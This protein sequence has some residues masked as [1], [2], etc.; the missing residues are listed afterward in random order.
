MWAASWAGGLPTPKF[1]QCVL[2]GF[3]IDCHAIACYAACVAPCMALALALALA[4]FCLGPFV[5]GAS[6]ASENIRELLRYKQMCGLLDDYICDAPGKG[7]P[8]FSMTTSHGDEWIPWQE[9]WMKGAWRARCYMQAAMVHPSL[10]V[11]CSGMR[12]ART[13]SP[14]AGT[15]ARARHSFVVCC[16]RLQRP[17]MASA[18]R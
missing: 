8:Q 9:L 13:S 15:V 18:M 17:R 12:R 11:L 5:V 14:S 1:M 7:D 10:P 4:P 3:R 16:L 2:L 6:M